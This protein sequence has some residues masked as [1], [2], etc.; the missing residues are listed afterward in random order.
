MVTIYKQ[1]VKRLADWS[2]KY[3]RDSIYG[4]CNKSDMDGELIKIEADA[5][6]AINQSNN[7]EEEKTSQSAPEENDY[8][9]CAT[10]VLNVLNYSKNSKHGQKII[11]IIKSYLT[12]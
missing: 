9:K 10:D 12:K 5:V 1:I 4:Y 11:S 7:I 8:N 6:A 3:P 2:T